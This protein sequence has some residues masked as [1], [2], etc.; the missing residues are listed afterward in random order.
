MNTANYFDGA[1]EWVKFWAMDK[2][3]HAYWYAC[4]PRIGEIQW[5]AIPTL[6]QLRPT[7]GQLFA[8]PDFGYSG[9][10][11]QSLKQREPAAQT[12]PSEIDRLKALNA[13]LAEALE[14]TLWAIQADGS[15]TCR[16]V[17]KLYET[18]LNEARAA[19]ANYKKET[20]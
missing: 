1:P 11:Q 18:N 14:I 10:W 17:K 9:D 15:A 3:G 4:Q 8:A 6:G 16:Q 7:L 19:L 12:A 13:E 2:H 20:A 5:V